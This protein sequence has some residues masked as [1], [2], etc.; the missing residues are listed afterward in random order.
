L[1]T[2]AGYRGEVPVLDIKYFGDSSSGCPENTGLE[3]V[4]VTFRAL[5]VVVLHI[6]VLVAAAESR[7]T[8]PFRTDK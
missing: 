4:I 1:A 6:E 8:K 5:P 2:G 3:F 7:L